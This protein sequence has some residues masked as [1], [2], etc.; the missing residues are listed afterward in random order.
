MLDLQRGILEKPELEWV[1]IGLGGWGGGR[2][3]GAQAGRL[4]GCVV[5]LEGPLAEKTLCAR[6]LGNGQQRNDEEAQ[7]QISFHIVQHSSVI[8]VVFQWPSQSVP[9]SN[10]NRKSNFF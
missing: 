3:R 4:H 9:C 7:S 10:R 1:R 5:E 8:L 2:R 6:R